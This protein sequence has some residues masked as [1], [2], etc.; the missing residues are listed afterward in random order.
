MAQNSAPWSDNLTPFNTTGIHMV[1]GNQRRPP[2][3]RKDHLRLKAEYLTT[4]L[5][6]VSPYTPPPSSYSGG[7]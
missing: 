5:C 3:M 2:Q 1:R 6:R 4:D 7:V